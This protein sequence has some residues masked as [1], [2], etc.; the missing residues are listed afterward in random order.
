MVC[1]SNI[2]TSPIH[3]GKLHVGSVCKLSWTAQPIST[4]KSSHPAE[5]CNCQARMLHLV[6]NSASPHLSSHLCINVPCA[7]SKIDVACALH[8]SRSQVASTQHSVLIWQKQICNVR[9]HARGATFVPC[10]RPFEFCPLLLAS[11]LVSVLC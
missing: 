9:L 3:E 7:H 5:L 2:H 11:V 1:A 4:I 6:Q 10:A 8:T